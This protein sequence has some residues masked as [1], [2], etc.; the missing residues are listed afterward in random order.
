MVCPH[1]FKFR[2]GFR[3][4]FQAGAV[5]QGAGQDYPTGRHQR[6]NKLV[7]G[8]MAELLMSC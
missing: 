2:S 3:V 6:N 7:M 8:L 4:F 5:A 1:V